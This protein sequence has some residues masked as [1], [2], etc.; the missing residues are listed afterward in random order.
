MIE[1]KALLIEEPSLSK[2]E[3]QLKMSPGFNSSVTKM[4]LLDERGTQWLVLE[5][6][7][8]PLASIAGEAAALTSF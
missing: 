6:S 7:T 8:D 3:H 5:P 2:E 1:R 4:R